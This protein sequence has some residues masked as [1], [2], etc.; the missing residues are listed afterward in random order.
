MKN[1]NPWIA[2]GLALLMV[3]CGDEGGG[4]GSPTINKLNAASTEYPS[5]SPPVPAIN[6]SAKTDINS[7]DPVTVADTD[8]DTNS[9]DTSTK[10]S[11]MTAL[12]STQVSIKRPNFNAFTDNGKILRTIKTH[13]I[14]NNSWV[15]LYQTKEATPSLQV[16]LLSPDKNSLYQK[17]KI[18]TFNF[19]GSPAKVKEIFFTNVDKDPN[20]ELIILT[21]WDVKHSGLGINAVEYQVSIY[22]NKLNPENNQ[23]QPLD[24][25][26]AKFGL[27]MDG[28]TEEGTESYEWKDKAAIL[29]GIKLLSKP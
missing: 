12:K 25:L 21:T 27:G 4:T 10:N 16:I 18:D 2:S 8:T 11:N 7:T 24:K 5:S 9:Y 20:K 23:V 26:M 1:S 28:V 3:A 13:F 17:I 15:V 6:R 29:K 19:E 14:K 22:D